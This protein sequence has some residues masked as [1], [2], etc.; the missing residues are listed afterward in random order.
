MKVTAILVLP[1]LALTAAVP[2]LEDR[3]LPG[4]PGL[5]PLPLDPVCLADITGISAC[6]T[7]GIN[8]NTLL[9]NLLGC[10]LLV[11]FQALDCIISGLGSGLDTK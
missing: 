4:F 1:I 8:Q 6:T 9:T 11:I 7:G 3:Q 5:P 10:P 2:K